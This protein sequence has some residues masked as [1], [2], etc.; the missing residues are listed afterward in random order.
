MSQTVIC[1]RDDLIENSGVC[2]LVNNQQI[3]LF[4]LPDTEQKI[5]A[6]EN[7]DPIGKAN[8]MSRGMVGSI[9]EELVVASPLY[10]QHYSLI[11]GVC[12]EE[13]LRLKTYEVAIQ[14][15]AVVLLG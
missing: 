4:L 11:T 9:G 13:D 3:A 10:K 14:D 7:W 12:I 6:I 8:V 5:F 1:S 15:D 2:A